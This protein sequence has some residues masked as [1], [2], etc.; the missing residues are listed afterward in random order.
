MGELIANPHVSELH[1]VKEARV[2]VVKLKW[3]DI[4]MDM[5]FARVGLAQIPETLD[6]TSDT[7][8]RSMDEQSVLSLNGCRVAESILLL[9]PDV[10]NFRLALRFIKAWAKRREI[11]SNVL[12][13]FAGVSLAILMARVCQLYPN[14]LPNVLVTRF[15]RVY[16]NWAWPKPVILGHTQE[17]SKGLNFH[18]WNPKTHYKDAQHLLPVITPVFPAMNSMA[19][20]SNSTYRAMRAEIKRGDALATSLA[21]NRS[22]GMSQDGWK[23]LIEPSSLFL[24]YKHFL[25]LDVASATVAD[26]V[27][28]FSLVESRLRALIVALQ[29][30]PDVSHVRVC[31]TH[32]DSKGAAPYLVRSSVYLALVFDMTAIKGRSGPK[33]VDLTSQKETFVNLVKRDQE[34]SEKSMFILLRHIRREDLPDA[35][36]PREHLSSRPRKTGKRKRGEELAPLDAVALGETLQVLEEVPRIM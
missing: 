8:L 23:E 19:Y 1:P 26:H 30:M 18:V 22:V 5:L 33:E 7:I 34:F 14:A 31:P 32:V 24:D 2:P 6:L 17:K 21:V 20:T 9:I 35:V 3:G 29:K 4:D 28:W 25:C 13:Y 36:F 12:G 10:D 11:Y 15:F 27:I 16:E